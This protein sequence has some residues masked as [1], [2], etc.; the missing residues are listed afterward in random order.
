MLDIQI[1]YT[2]ESNDI[3]LEKVPNLQE[4]ENGSLFIKKNLIQKV[5]QFLEN[6][7]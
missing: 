1:I 7:I 5:K 4:E 6:I 3:I 2:I